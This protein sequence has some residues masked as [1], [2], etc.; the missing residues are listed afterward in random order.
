MYDG[1]HMTTGGWIAREIL[2]R[3]LAAGEIDEDEYLGLRMT[4]SRTQETIP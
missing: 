1:D 2:D 4:L 3:R